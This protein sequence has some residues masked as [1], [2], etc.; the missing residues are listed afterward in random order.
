MKRI[1]MSLCFAILPVASSWA[2]GQE[3]HSIVAEIA[4]R[5]LLPKASAEVYRLLGNNHSLASVASWADDERDARPET[6]NWHFVDIPIASSA[7]DAK[8]QCAASGAGDCVVAEL[9]RLKSDLRCAGTDDQKR[10]ALRFAV[11]FLGDIHQP[12]H[13]VADSKGGNSLQVEVKMRGALMC[14][15]APCPI[16]TAHTN[17]HAV[18]DTTLITKT[19]WDW[20]AYTDRLEQGWLKTPEA[21]GSADG[22]SIVDWATSTHAAA[23]VVWNALPQDH[24]LDDNYYQLAQPILDKQL[25]LAGI[26]LARF[27]NEAYASNQCPRP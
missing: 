26:R 19:T 22:G 5:R 16:F 21:Q 17:F 24:V 3:G 15:G 7:F 10:D 14:K 6:Y 8:S 13:T 18:W 27:L 9:E 4:Q 12:L 1:L 23:Q 11:H 2:W 20:G 25:G